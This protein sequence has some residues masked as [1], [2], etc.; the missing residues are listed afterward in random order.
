MTIEFKDFKEIAKGKTISFIGKIKTKFSTSQ[1]SN[2]LDKVRG[3][4]EE[5]LLQKIEKYSKEIEAQEKILESE[6]TTEKGYENAKEIIYRNRVD[7]EKTRKKLDKLYKTKKLEYETINKLRDYFPQ[8]EAEELP[9]LESYYDA[10]A[11]RFYICGEELNPNVYED[12][13]AIINNFKDYEYSGHGKWARALQNYGAAT[14]G[15]DFIRL[16]SASDNKDQFIDNLQGTY[17]EIEEEIG[18]KE[19]IKLNAK[20]ANKVREF[21][22]TL[23]LPNLRHLIETTKKE[24]IDPETVEISK[25]AVETEIEQTEKQMIDPEVVD[26]SK[27]VVET[28]Q[29]LEPEPE[30]MPEPE[31]DKYTIAIEQAKEKQEEIR[32]KIQALREDYLADVDATE[33]RPFETKADIMANT[34]GEVAEKRAVLEQE[35]EAAIKEENDAFEARRNEKIE[36]MKKAREERIKAINENAAKQEKEKQALAKLE[37]AKT[38]LSNIETS[39]GKYDISNLTDEEIMEVYEAVT[40]PKSAAE[41]NASEETINVENSTPEDTSNQEETNQPVEQELQE[42]KDDV[43]NALMNSENFTEEQAKALANSDNPEV[44]DMVQNYIEQEVQ[45]KQVETGGKTR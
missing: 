28:E 15:E 33:L 42:N 14:V 36:Q 30:P 11:D 32:A 40:N 22:S 20:P 13:I 9:K 19:M 8:L 2:L 26:A 44:Q 45:I 4:N 7:L 34:Y 43:V 27:P 6:N 29:V 16:F 35:L 12:K 38:L 24:I 10:N 17:L 5:R 41:R 1:I 37:E 23:N 3:R 31:K 21:L 25:P 18:P 39:T